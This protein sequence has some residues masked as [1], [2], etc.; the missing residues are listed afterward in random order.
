MSTLF[1]NIERIQLGKEKLKTSIE[2]KNV[3]VGDISFNE[4]ADKIDDISYINFECIGYNK[5]LSN[6]LNSEINEPLL[7]SKQLYDEWDSSTT[8][9][10]SLYKNDKQLV[11]APNIDT[12]NVT[13]MNSMFYGC[14]SLTTLPLL[15]TS[16]VTNM[17]RMFIDCSSL[18]S[19]PLFD[20][21][22]VT[23]M[24]YMFYGCSSLQSIP[25]LNTSKVTDMSYM[26]DGCSKLTTLSLLDTSKVTSMSRI[27]GASNIN[28]LTDLGGF[29]DLK[30]SITSYFLDKAP[31]LTV[32]SLMNV[33]NNLFDLTA[34]G[35]VGRT[36]KF[37]S[38]NLN[39][40]TAEQI[41]VAT[42][43]GW[44]LTA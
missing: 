27:F 39:K 17:I 36:L 28:T 20:C 24:L 11:Y 12:S 32:E 4:Y 6:E 30:I 34:N 8:S 26:F 33:I 10:S 23:N 44:T 43:K 35:L 3:E 18:Q 40:L 1:E 13:N 5:Q 42:A 15:N 37:G 22:N 16:N 25:E 19:I 38:T 9:T 41:A 21:G 14:S 29:K 31:N 7:Y 2:N